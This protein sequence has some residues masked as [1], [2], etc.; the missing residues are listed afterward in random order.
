MRRTIAVTLVAVAVLAAGCANPSSESESVTLR[1]S[2]DDGDTF[3][4]RNEYDMA[5]TTEIEGLPMEDV[6]DGPIDI[7]LSAALTTRY[8]VSD[9][10]EPGTYA[11]TFGYDEVSDLAMTMRAGG[12]EM[13][14]TEDDLAGELAGSGVPLPGNE[15]EFIVDS[16]GHILSVNVDGTPVPLPGVAGGGLSGFG[17]ETPF[18]GPEMPEGP[19]AVGDT[20]TAEWSVEPFPGTEMQVSAQ[21]HLLSVETVDGAE[22][23]V[24]ETTT[25]ATPLDVELA[26]ILGGL[27]A[28]DL[29]GGPADFG[30]TMRVAATPGRSTVWFDPARGI[31]VRQEFAGGADVTMSFQ[32][33]GQSG[34]M[35]MRTTMEGSLRLVP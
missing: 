28:E 17:S 30:L 8:A 33:E 24:I 1:Y 3:T 2:L 4:Y 31:T 15:V 32:G 10:T 21:S 6:P 18:L 22:V 12:E 11:V 7:D 27:A 20:W 19:V 23:Y 5:M 34:S 29:A 35:T 9:G 14:F 26:D 16:S 25:T 13:T